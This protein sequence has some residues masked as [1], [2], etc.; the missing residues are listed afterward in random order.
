MFW[1]GIDTATRRG[2]VALAPAGSVR[3][4]Q[5]GG[6]HAPELLEAIEALLTAAGAGAKDLAGIAVALGP[7]SFTGVRVGLA[8]AK[9]LGYALGIPVAGLS[10]LEIL[11]RAAGLAPGALVCAAIEAG[12]GEVYAARFRVVQEGVERLTDDA[13]SPPA[14]VAETLEGREFVAGDGAARVVAAAPDRLVPAPVAPLAPVLADWAARTLP[15]GTPYR[16]GGPAPNYVRPSDGTP[17]R[18]RS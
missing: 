1:L 16:P 4:L 6:G 9:G 15:A 7:G 5:P 14:R 8:T 18:P 11:A 2:S 3:L 12:R 13:A 17:P 10:S